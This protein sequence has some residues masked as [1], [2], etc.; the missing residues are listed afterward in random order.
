MTDFNAQ[1][2][3]YKRREQELKAREQD[4]RLREL[5]LEIQRL[6]DPKTPAPEAD[7]SPTQKHVEKPGFMQRFSRK[8]KLAA[9]FM[10]F[11]A[12]G[13]GIVAIGH[14]IVGIAFV[15]LVGAVAYFV[16]FSGKFES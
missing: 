1:D 5:E 7:Y 2:A 12:L 6:E 8:A 4:I 14:F 10:A 11:A 13:L 15:F 3:D 9:Q 16:I